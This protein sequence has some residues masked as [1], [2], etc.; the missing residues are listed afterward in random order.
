MRRS[1]AFRC[2]EAGLDRPH[3]RP[4]ERPA[5]RNPP[6]LSAAKT[7]EPRRLALVAPMKLESKQFA[8][9]IFVNFGERRPDA[10]TLRKNN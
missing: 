7:N 6:A 1:P 10:S 3:E 8:A 4:S 5:T 9:L 2:S